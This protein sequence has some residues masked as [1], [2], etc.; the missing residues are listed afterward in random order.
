MRRELITCLLLVAALAAPP[1]SGA[2]RSRAFHGEPY[3]LPE[4][5]VVLQSSQNGCGPAAIATLSAWYGRPVSEATVL[6][7]AAL[8]ESGVSLSEF[9]RLADRQG[10]PGAWYRIPKHELALLPTPF[11]AHLDG[12]GGGHF[13][14][15]HAIVGAHVVLADPAEG[16]LAAPLERLSQ[17]F[18]GRAYLPR[19]LA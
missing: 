16:S 13:V 3:Q 17:T 9:A 14:V 8:S 1:L 19:R 6:S 15:V 4:L 5:P 10:L 11:V 12:R 18:S 7:G 2:E